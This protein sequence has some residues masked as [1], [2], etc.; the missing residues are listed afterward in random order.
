[1]YICMYYIQF[2]LKPV[3]VPVYT[4]IWALHRHVNFMLFC[5]AERQKISDKKSG[6]STNESQGECRGML[7]G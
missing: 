7:F 1:M 6:N 3:E 5:P 2:T 4:Y